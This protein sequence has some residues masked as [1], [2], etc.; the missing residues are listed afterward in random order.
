MKLFAN[1]NTL[2]R[3]ATIVTI[4][5]CGLTCESASRF[6]PPPADRVLWKVTGK[7]FGIVPSYDSTTVFFASIDHHVVAIDRETGRTRW[8]ASTGNGPGGATVGFNTVVAGDV[9]AVGDADVYAFNRQTGARAWSFRAS[10]DDETG[11]HALGTDGTTIYASSYLGRVYAFDSHTGVPHW[12]T[13]LSGP[14]GVQTTTFDPVAAG[15]EIFVGL[16]YGTNPVTG[17]LAALDASTGHLL[18]TRDFT[19]IR[20][21]L[22]SFCNGGAVVA[23]GLVIASAGDGRIYGLDTA[24]G[25][26]RWTAPQVPNYDTG[27][28]RALALSQDLVIASSSSGHGTGIDAATGAIVWSKV[29]D[30]AS[31]TY[32]VAADDEIAVFSTSELIAVNP[33]TGSVLWRTGTGKQGGDFWGYSAAAPDRVFGNGIDGFYALKKE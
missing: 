20:P 2:G 8:Q 18:W 24:S 17:G 25:E 13:Q 5:G 1:G 28:F 12:T 21:D 15:G 26:V 27:D 33:Q 19:P 4:L 9:V 29:I 23:D 7:G 14:P 16:W 22:E 31:L 11:S 3:I 6:A 32:H 30:G 10:D